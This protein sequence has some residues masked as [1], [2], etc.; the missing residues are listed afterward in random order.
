MWTEEREDRL[1]RIVRTQ[2]INKNSAMLQ[3]AISLKRELRRETRLIKGITA[4]M[5]RERRQEKKA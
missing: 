5:I 3:T 4:E 1:I 2:Q